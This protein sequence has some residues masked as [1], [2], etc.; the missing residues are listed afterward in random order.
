MA[1]AAVLLLFDL[2]DD[3]PLDAPAVTLSF[4]SSSVGGSPAVLLLL[5]FDDLPSF[6]ADLL[7]FSR[8]DIPSALR[9]PLLLVL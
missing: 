8:V 5:F 2:D 6:L 9:L 3:L 1:A 4:E 7:L